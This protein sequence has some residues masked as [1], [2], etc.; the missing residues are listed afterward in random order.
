MAITLNDLTINLEGVDVKSLLSDW[1]WAMEESMKP[2]LVTAM[3]DVF[4]QGKSG[5]VYF[6]D[7]VGGTI[8]CIAEDGSEFEELLT[9]KDFVTDL[10][11]PARVIENRKAGLSLG[12]KEVYSNCTPLVLGGEDDVENIETTDVSVHV[13]IHGQIHKQVK[14]L[15]PGTPIKNIKIK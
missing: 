11:Y 13:S 9:N 1:K 8:E 14:D 5:A 15:P 3:G 6:V 10:M 2:V 12:P 4:A 7:V